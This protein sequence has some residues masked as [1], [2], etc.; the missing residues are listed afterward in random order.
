[1]EKVQ[2][3][4]RPK[5]LD[6]KKVR[7]TDSKGN[8]KEYSYA[9][10]HNQYGNVEDY[11]SRFRGPFGSAEIIDNTPP[12]IKAQVNAYNDPETQA[13]LKEDEKARKAT[14]DKLNKEKDARDR[15]V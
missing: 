2:N 3:E 12:N 10:I 1:M 9:S 8:T 7:I 6:Y 15:E 5:D 14:L 4:I 11:V 13:K